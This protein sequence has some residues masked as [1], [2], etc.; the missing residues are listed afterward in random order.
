MLHTILLV[1]GITLVLFWSSGEPS[2]G[3]NLRVDFIFFTFYT[4]NS[5]WSEENGLPGRQ[6]WKQKEGEFCFNLGGNGGGLIV[7]G[8]R[9]EQSLDFS[10]G[11][12]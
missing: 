4:D 10:G 2:E 7:M 3:F 5:G 1:S 9:S 6:E 12:T 11:R 8:S